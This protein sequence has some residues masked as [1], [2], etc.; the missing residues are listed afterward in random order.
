M[1]KLPVSILA[2]LI[3]SASAIAGTNAFFSDP[4]TSTNNNLSAGEID[5]KIDNTSYYNGEASPETSWEL[6]DLTVERFLDFKDLKPGDYGEDTI[7]LHVN[8]NPAWL[9]ANLTLTE[10]DDKSSTEP[11][12]G[13]GDAE[14]DGGN[15]FDGELASHIKFIFWRDDGDNVLETDEASSSSQ[16]AQGLAKNVLNATWTLADSIK[17]KLGGVNGEPA[18]ADQTY[19]IGKAWCFGNMSLSAVTPGN[20]N[21][22]IDPG[23]DCS[24]SAENNITQSDSLKADITFTAVQARNNATFKCQGEDCVIAENVFAN[25]VFASN[26][27]NRKDGSDVLPAR[28]T[29]SNA[30]GVP[31]GNGALGTGFFSLGFGGSLVVKFNQPVVNVDGFDLSFHEI[32]NGRATF[33]LEKALVEVSPDG[34]NFTS[35]GEVT[36]QSSEGGAGIG[37][38]DFSPTGFSWI[39]YIRLTDTTNPA[40]HAA[41]ADGYDI[42]AIDAKKTDSCAN[43]L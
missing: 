7:S 37:L 1:K 13:D 9:C 20:N 36:S 18:K 34:V 23:I 12:L 39:L 35:I 41:T 8:T 33:P 43:Q 21:P 31:D 10:D 3:A 2:I 40:I 24:G 38:K 5:L 17:N 32:T 22:L 6:K 27:G 26:Q 25:S 4:E 19:Y 11:E 42:D 16:I 28:S 14:E 30:L 29:P 15:L